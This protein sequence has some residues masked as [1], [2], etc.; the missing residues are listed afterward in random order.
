MF[1]CFLAFDFVCFNFGQLKLQD[2]HNLALKKKI[3][4]YNYKRDEE[5]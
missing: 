5:E 4:V 2:N 3:Q 1:V